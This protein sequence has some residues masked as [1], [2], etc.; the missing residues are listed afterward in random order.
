MIRQA[1]YQDRNGVVATVAAAFARDPGW[2]FILG[3]EYG[4]LAADFAGALFD[5]RIAGKNVWVT[6][7]LAGGRI[8]GGCV[9]VRRGW[10]PRELGGRKS[11]CTRHQ[12]WLNRTWLG[13]DGGGYSGWETTKQAARTEVGVAGHGGGMVEPEDESPAWEAA[14]IA[15]G[16]PF[17]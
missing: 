12:R 13:G 16:P 14:K 5:V 10:L 9:G 11:K 2:A 15:D 8:H 17:R 7:D 4:C 1:H 6:D 3:E